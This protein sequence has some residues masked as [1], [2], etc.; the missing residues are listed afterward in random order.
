MFKFLK[1]KLKQAVSKISKKAEAEAPEELKEVLTE[2]KLILKKP[3]KEKKPPTTKTS[4]K[5]VK[6]SKDTTEEQLSQEL[7]PPSEEQAK[8]EKGFFKKLFKKEQTEKQPPLETAAAPPPQQEEAPVHIPEEPAKRGIFEVIK[9]KIITKKISSDQFDKLF[10]E[11]EMALLENNAAFDVI[12]KIKTDLKAHIVDKPI[13]RGRIFSVIQQHLKQSIENLFTATPIDLVKTITNYK[14]KPYIIV[15]VGVNGSGKTT[16]IAKIAYLLRK[17]NLTPLLV[18]GDTW[19]AASIQQ[20]EEQGKKIGA[21]VIK[22]DYG[23]DPAAVA[24]DG[25]K[26]AQHHNLDVVLIDTAGRQHSNKNLMNEME[27]IVRVA[28][29]HLKIFVGEAIVGNDAV[30]QSQHFND[31]VGIDGIILTKGDVDEKGGAFISVSYI[32]GKPILY[33]GSGQELTDLEPFDA[34]K[35]LTTLGF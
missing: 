8:K 19:R 17:H 24:F 14:A 20:L 9:E 34:H 26:Y 25:I 23:S 11:L 33:W 6:P 35:I 16:T 7:A 22:H 5:P 32:T 27:K 18:A 2:K 1:D 30:E 28:K 12:E 13:K 4:K 31:A 21:K 3:V 15:F 29:P 10:E